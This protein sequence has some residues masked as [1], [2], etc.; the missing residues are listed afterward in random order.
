MQMRLKT[1]KF[2]I[3]LVGHESQPSLFAFAPARQMGRYS[4]TV[5]SILKM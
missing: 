5:T 2:T 3:S 4:Q 1:E